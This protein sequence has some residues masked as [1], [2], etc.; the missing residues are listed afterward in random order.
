M[1]VVLKGCVQRD[2]PHA[3]LLSEN[4]SLCIVT[5]VIMETFLAERQ[6]AIWQILRFTVFL[7][8]QN[9]HFATQMG[10]LSNIS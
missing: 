10:T 5:I 3:L 6:R 2:E 4:V 9:Q 1:P 7:L 8:K